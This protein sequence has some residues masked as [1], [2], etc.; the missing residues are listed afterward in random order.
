M[1][2]Y[3]LLYITVLLCSDLM[4]M[5]SFIQIQKTCGDVIADLFGKE[6]LKPD[7]KQK[8]QRIVEELEMSHF[9]V[10]ARAMNDFAFSHTGRGNAL[11]FPGMSYLFIDE[12]FF[13]E[14]TQDEQ[15]FLIGHELMH[16]YRLHGIKRLVFLSSVI[17]ACFALADRLN[18]IDIEKLIT[19]PMGQK[20]SSVATVTLPIM[21][22]ILGILATYRLS[23]SQELDADSKVVQKLGKKAIAGGLS[24]LQRYESCDDEKFD[25]K[26][27]L[28]YQPT[29]KERIANLIKLQDQIV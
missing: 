27:L 11:V 14:L 5:P 18:E 28:S 7:N 12:E 4:S 17:V 29:I 8:V 24:L 20:L 13:E 21:L 16:I 26:A 23:R 9:M 10:E 6:G 2:F 3:K 22:M 25:F 1:S 19:S 15:R